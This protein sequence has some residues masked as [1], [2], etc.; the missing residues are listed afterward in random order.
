MPANA[1]SWQLDNFAARVSLGQWTGELDLLSP[2]RGIALSSGAERLEVLGVDLPAIDQ[3]TAANEL[4]FYVRGG[5]LVATYHETPNRKRRGQVYWRLVPLG[6]SIAH[7]TIELVAS[8][9][10]SLLD[11]D[12]TLEINSHI[13]ANEVLRLADPVNKRTTSLPL[14]NETHC[15]TQ[16]SCSRHM[17]W[18]RPIGSVSTGSSHTH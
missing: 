6:A 11:S 7:D 8:M 14:S 3:K 1:S 10:T 12:P 13:P 17:T 4:E 5:D 15:T 16:P 2:A 9:Q 18:T